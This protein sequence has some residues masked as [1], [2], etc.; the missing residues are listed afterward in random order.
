MEIKYCNF[1]IL[2]LRFKKMIRGV[3][4][5]QIYMMGFVFYMC[6]QLSIIIIITQKVVNL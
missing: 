3:H 6:G 1:L 2:R 4:I 5:F